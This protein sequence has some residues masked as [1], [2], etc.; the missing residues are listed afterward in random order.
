MMK[1]MK[2]NATMEFEKLA[3]TISEWFTPIIRIWRYTKNNGIIEVF[4]RKMKLIKRRAYEYR[5]FEFKRSANEIL[6]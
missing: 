5:N 4:H 1:Q 6:P 3:E 2:Y